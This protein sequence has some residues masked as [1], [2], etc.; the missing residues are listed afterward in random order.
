MIYRMKK[1]GSSICSTREQKTCTSN[2]KERESDN[3]NIHPFATY[4]DALWNVGSSW[5]VVCAWW[6]MVPCLRRMAQNSH[7]HMAPKD[8][9]AHGS[10]ASA[11]ISILMTF[12]SSERFSWKPCYR[13]QA[14]SIA[15]GRNHSLSCAALPPHRENMSSSWQLG[16][17]DQTNE[18]TNPYTWAS[19]S[20]TWWKT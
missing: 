11:S 2:I 20:I 17:T 7:W 5:V 13:K 3:T 8:D 4:G 10:K 6:C 1:G 12:V 19:S 9:V 18:S 16:K 14:N 15:A